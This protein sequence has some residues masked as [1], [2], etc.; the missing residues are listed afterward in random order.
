MI[1]QVGL[2]EFHNLAPFMEMLMDF[3]LVRNRIE[4]YKMNRSLEYPIQIHTVKKIANYMVIHY[5]IP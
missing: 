1:F 2:R 4:L 3:T 5:E